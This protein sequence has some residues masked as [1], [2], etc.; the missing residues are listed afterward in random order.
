MYA[1]KKS[2][3]EQENAIPLEDAVKYKTLWNKATA[4]IAK[5]RDIINGGGGLMFSCEDNET[6]K[7]LYAAIDALD[8]FRQNLKLKDSM[9]EE[10]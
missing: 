7:E 2:D 9:Q 1:Y 4:C 3:K 5:A 8:R 6:K 10:D